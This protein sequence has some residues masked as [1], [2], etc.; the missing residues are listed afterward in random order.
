MECKDKSFSEKFQGINI[1]YYYYLSLFRNQYDNLI[2]QNAK[3]AAP[4]VEAAPFYYIRKSWW[5]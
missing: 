1:N 2:K 3:G 5:L 4:I